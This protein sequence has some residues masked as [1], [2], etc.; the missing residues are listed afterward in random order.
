MELA[1]WPQVTGMSFPPWRNLTTKDLSKLISQRMGLVP[2]PAALAER[3]VPSAL[4]AQEA[5]V[6]AVPGTGTFPLAQRAAG[7][8]TAWLWAGSAATYRVLELD[9][10]VS[11]LLEDC[12]PHC[13]CVGGLL[14]T[15][16]ACNHKQHQEL[17]YSTHTSLLEGTT[18][19]APGRNLETS[20]HLPECLSTYP[21]LQVL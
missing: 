9:T 16:A 17:V 20:V 11:T 18:T 12:A 4:L 19:P 15:A 7:L 5:A 13:R 3:A 10:A 2:A 1:P 14:P 21:V 8:V 6:R